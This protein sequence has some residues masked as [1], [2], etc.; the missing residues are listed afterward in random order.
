MKYE[1]KI[2]GKVGGKFIE[3]DTTK[4]DQKNMENAE[5]LKLAKAA[6]SKYVKSEGC[7]CCR[8]IDAHDAAAAEIAEALGFEKYEDG[9]GFDFY[10]I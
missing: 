6:F 2:Y 1:G 9:S 8:D 10:S 7:A 4:D 5:K 3:L